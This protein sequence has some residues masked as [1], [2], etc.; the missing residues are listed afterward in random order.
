MQK[1]K[2]IGQRRRASFW[3]KHWESSEA[4]LQARDGVLRSTVERVRELPE[5]Q[6]F[7]T[8]AEKGWGLSKAKAEDPNNNWR[9]ECRPF[10]K[11]R[12]AFWGTKAIEKAL[13][14]CCPWRLTLHY[15]AQNA[16][17]ARLVAFAVTLKPSEHILIQ[18]NRQLLF[19]GG[20]GDRRLL[21]KGL[22]EPRNVRIVNIAILHTINP[23]QVAPDRFSV[24]VDFPFSWR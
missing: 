15:Y 17:D 24:H 4:F 23:C 22:V 19:R 18:A 8:M 21:E 13:P 3:N 12:R 6:N 14:M 1:Q 5:A 16:V 2:N 7:K 20:P 10:Q 9:L 11:E